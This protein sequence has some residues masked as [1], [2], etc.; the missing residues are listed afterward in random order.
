MGV[1]EAIILGLVQGLTEFLPISSSGHLY[2]VPGLFGW[3][4][5]GSGFTAVIQLGTLLAVFLYFWKDLTSIL[6]GWAKGMRDSSARGTQEWKLAWGIIAG[7]VPIA[8]AGLTL[9]KQID[10]AFRSPFVVAGTLAFFGILMGV[11]DLK[12]KRSKTLEDF[13]V[14]DGVIMGLWQC[15]ALI[16]GSSRSGCTITGGLFGG[17][18]RAVAARVSFLLSVPSV[19]ASGLYKLIKERDVLLSEGLVPTV[20]ATGVAFISGWIA[21]AFLMKFLQTKSTM[22]FV[23]YRLVLAAAIIVLVTQ[24]IVQFDTTEVAQSVDVVRQMIVLR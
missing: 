24:G 2:I 17:F 23:V 10:T 13:R 15:L 5:A 9:E 16:P 20:I 19:L 11:A 12:G 21:I 8:V 4:D 7:S 18:D 6:G 3:D 1:I 22:V 14:K